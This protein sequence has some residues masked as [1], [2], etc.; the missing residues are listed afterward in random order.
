MGFYNPDPN[1]DI[2]NE[3]DTRIPY[4]IDGNQVYPLTYT[5]DANGITTSTLQGCLPL[6]TY[7][8][9]DEVYD[10]LFSQRFGTSCIWW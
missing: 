7:D 10:T 4:F 8:W 6:D 2:A 1:P 5:S 9:Q 3:V